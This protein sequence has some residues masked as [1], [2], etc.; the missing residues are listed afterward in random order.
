MFDK[1]EEKEVE[2]EEKQ[3]EEEE[4]REKRGRLLHTGKSSLD[5]IVNF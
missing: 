4:K 5:T 3:E 2:N 1:E